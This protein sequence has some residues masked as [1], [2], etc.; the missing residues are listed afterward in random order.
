[1]NFSCFKLWIGRLSTNLKVLTNE[2]RGGLKVPAFDRSPFK[3]FLLR[4]SAKSVQALSCERP[5]TTQQTLFVSFE[6][7]NCFP[8]VILRRGFMKKNGKLACHLVNW[9]ITIDSSLTLQILLKTVA[10]FEKDLWWW[11]YSYSCLKYWGGCT[12]PLCPLI[13]W[14]EKCVSSRH[15]SV[16]GN[17]QIIE[18]VLCLSQDGS[19][20]NLFENFRENNLKRDI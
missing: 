9:N 5:K 2:K 16:L 17:K 15:C 1:M 19:C 3:L 11:S 20:T 7:K 4:F 18:T 14:C 8:M 13:V 6:I 10:L 12:I